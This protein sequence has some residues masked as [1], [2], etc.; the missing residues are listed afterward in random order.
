MS[1]KKVMD[2]SLNLLFSQ[3]YLLKKDL[4]REELK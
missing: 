4:E 1:R 3:L 2:G